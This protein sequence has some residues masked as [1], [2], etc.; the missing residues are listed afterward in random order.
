LQTPDD[1]TPINGTLSQTLGYISPNN[2]VGSGGT[3]AAAASTTFS[4]NSY[5][6]TGHVF[7]NNFSSGDDR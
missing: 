6:P 5:K 1:A 2:Q 3:G 4:I 7:T